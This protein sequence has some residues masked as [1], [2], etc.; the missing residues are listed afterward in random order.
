[1]GYLIKIK[2]NIKLEKPCKTFV[3]TEKGKT[4]FV[5]ESELH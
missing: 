3:K 1:M 5:L 2:N 4:T